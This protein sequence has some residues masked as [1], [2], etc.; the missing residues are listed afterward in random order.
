MADVRPASGP[1][2]AGPDPEEDPGTPRWVKAFGIVAVILVLLFI[3]LHLAGG[4][5][6]GH[7]HG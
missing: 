2:D 5:F 1:G 7:G 3:A 4:G 6:R